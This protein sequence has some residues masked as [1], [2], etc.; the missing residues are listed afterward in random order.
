MAADN[1]TRSL[2]SQYA[3]LRTSYRQ[4]KAS[5]S[6]V[7]IDKHESAS[8]INT[9][10]PWPTGSARFFL[11][12]PSNAG[13]TTIAVRLI[14]SLVNASLGD[15]AGQRAYTQLTI[16]SPNIARDEKIKGVTQWA[17]KKGLAVV[18]FP[19]NVKDPKASRE[20][21]EKFENHMAD[22]QRKGARTVSYV[23][24][25][26]GVNGF[27]DNVN[28]V[29]PFNA[30]Q[31]SIKHYDATSIFSTQASGAMSRTAKLVTDVY[32]MLPDEMHRDDYWKLCKF[33]RH[34]HHFDAI[35]DRLVS[36]EAIWVNTQFGK[37]GVYHLSRQGDLSAITSP[38]K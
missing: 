14:K 30:F 33:V 9:N 10:P 31:A 18:L 7:K 8:W 4:P 19:L 13:K 23:D 36:F 28:R 38:P 15:S 21:I 37:K 16:M 6:S 2:A 20:T 29:S 22:S 32:I 34:R 24:D 12:G 26:V 1:P 11:L 27:T 35:M 5:T 25:P 17:A 3:A